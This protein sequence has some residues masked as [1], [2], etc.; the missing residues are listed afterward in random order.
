MTLE[1]FRKP[2]EQCTEWIDDCWD[3]E[4]LAEAR[5]IAHSLVGRF[6][7]QFEYIREAEKEARD[8]ERRVREDEEFERSSTPPPEGS[9]P[10]PQ[11]VRDPAWEP[12]HPLDPGDRDD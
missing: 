9:Y 7:R 4:R 2:I 12:G 10:N 1:S 8:H 11:V 3:P 5:E 6:S